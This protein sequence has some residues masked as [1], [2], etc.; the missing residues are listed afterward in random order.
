[1]EPAHLLVLGRLVFV[2][3]A[4]DEPE[5]QHLSHLLGR[6]LPQQLGRLL[7]CGLHLVLVPAA[8]LLMNCLTSALSGCSK[9]PKPGYQG[10][11]KQE[12]LTYLDIT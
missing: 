3:P 2:V 4:P 12:A 11:P 7:D 8:V 5:V 10:L 9:K 1:M 6:E